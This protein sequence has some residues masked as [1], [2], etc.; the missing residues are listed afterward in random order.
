MVNLISCE[1][2]IY[3]L[4]YVYTRIVNSCTVIKYDAC[5][6][7]TFYKTINKQLQV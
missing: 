6:C 7:L 1:A 4:V 3:Y 2:V 5:V